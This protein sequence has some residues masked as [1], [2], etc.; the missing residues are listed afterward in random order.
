M[1]LAGWATPYM[2]TSKEIDD[3]TGLYY[4]GARFYDPRISV[5][6]GVD[7]LANE[8]SDMSPYVNTANNPI[9]FIDP[10]GLFPIDPNFRNNFPLLTKFIENNMESY[11]TNSSRI[12]AVLSKWSQGMLTA[13]QIHQDFQ[14]AEGPTIRSVKYEPN[15]IKQ[16]EYDGA[17]INLPEDKLIRWENFL[18]EGEEKGTWGLLDFS[19]LFIHEYL[20]YGDD[21]DGIQLTID[22]NGNITNSNI[23]GSCWGDCPFEEG[24]RGSNEAFPFSGFQNY[25]LFKYGDLYKS[26]GT[27][28]I[29]HNE[30][31][32]D[33]EMIPSY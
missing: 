7:P 5:G 18:K 8:A 1:R 20:H 16:A 24:V 30:S 9:R 12:M 17:N 10:D 32:I 11:F 31:Y 29:E 28:I 33:K 19:K 21:L 13:Q 26:D 14:S 3:N 4:Y 2:I 22:K 6:H 27:A 25:K 15:S 23:Y